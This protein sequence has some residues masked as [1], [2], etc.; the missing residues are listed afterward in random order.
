MP[1]PGRVL[2]E[3]MWIVKHRPGLGRGVGGAGGG[4]A[5]EH[6]LLRPGTVLLLLPLNERQGQSASN[7][8]ISSKLKWQKAKESLNF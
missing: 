6:L 2:K 5:F 8:V 4:V 3:E 1:G 7:Y